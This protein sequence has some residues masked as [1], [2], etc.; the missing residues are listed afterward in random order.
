MVAR[1]C[2]WCGLQFMAKPSHV[3]RSEKAGAPIYCGRVCAGLGRRKN[4]AVDQKRAE[5]QAYD[6]KRR[7]DLAD[8]IKAQKAEAYQRNKDPVKEAAARKK[9]MPQH[10]EYCRRPEYVAWKREYDKV[11]LAK[12]E[13]GEFW[14]S[15]LLA[16]EIRR[17]CLELSDDTEIRR[18]KGTL[19]KKMERRRNYDRTH[20]NRPEIGSLGHA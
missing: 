13:H 12:K 8:V 16:L 19:N 3:N 18:Q 15:A 6:K 14:E 10:V 7:A 17:T 11:Y 5:K 2:P 20:S 4:K 1:A 9:R